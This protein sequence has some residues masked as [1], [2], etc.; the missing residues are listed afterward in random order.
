VSHEVLL[1][2][3]ELHR[4][5]GIVLNWFRSYLH[6]RRQRVSLDCNATHS[7]VRLGVNKAWS[8]SRFDPGPNAVQYTCINN[9]P[10]IMNKLSH[11]ILY[12]DDTNITVKST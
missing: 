12:A 2:E 10:K 11:T 1:S 9:L 7:F 3:L 8:S 4:V 5:T 6:D